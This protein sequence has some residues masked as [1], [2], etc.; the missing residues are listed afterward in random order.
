MAKN[1]PDNLPIA[2]VTGA[3][4]GIGKAIAK[5]LI[6]LGF[7]V[8]GTSRHPEKI[9]EEDK[10]RDIEYLPLELTNEE[11]I[12]N[13]V[14]KLP[15]LQILINNAGSSQIGPIEEIPI[16]KVKEYFELSLFG[17]IN[18]TK[19]V[20]PQMRKHKEGTIINITS[21]ASRSPV[22][23]SVYYAAAKAGLNVFTRG[24]RS[25]LRPY[26]I[27]CIAIG[28]GPVKTT[29]VQDLQINSNSPYSE[30]MHAAQEARNEAII[31]GVTPGYIANRVIQIMHKSKP[32][33]YYA[34][35][36]NAALLDWLVKHLPEKLAEKIIWNKYRV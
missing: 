33:P 21:M 3:S 4:K 24:L 11:S 36:K 14:K 31:D 15:S 34:V 8:I 25:E 22:P 16:K 30:K 13:L 12:D 19:K 35:G 6:E 27:K 2:L 32:K 17:V 9:K 18:L 7:R 5:K 1:P 26:G 28:P 23:F 29:I 20:I 10:L